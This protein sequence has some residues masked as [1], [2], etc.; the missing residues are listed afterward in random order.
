MFCNLLLLSWTLLLLSISPL[1]AHPVSETADMSYA[2]PDIGEDAGAV[3]PEDLDFNSL[4]QRTAGLS[5]S[6]VF[7]KDGKIIDNCE[8]NCLFI[9]QFHC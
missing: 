1:L 7:S 3:D 4:I 8:L 6:P 5:Y 2:G 9:C